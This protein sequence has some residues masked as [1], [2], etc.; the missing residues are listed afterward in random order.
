MKKDYFKDLVSIYAPMSHHTSPRKEKIKYIVIHDTGNSSR[1]AG[2]DSHVRYFHTTDRKASCDFI[3]DS[4]HIAQ[5]T[6][7]TERASWHCGDGAKGNRTITNQN[8][9]GIEMCINSDDNYKK[10]YKNTLD[11]VE[12]LMTFLDIPLD[13]VVR[14][15]DASGK[16]CPNHMSKNGWALWQTFKRD[17][18]YQVSGAKE[19]PEGI[20]SPAEAKL[21]FKQEEKEITIKKVDV[22]G[23]IFV[24]LYDLL[25]LIGY[26]ASKKDQSFYISR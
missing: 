5:I 8:S 7:F 13:R 14:H 22:D 12:A 4:K 11:I 18:A 1:G 24:P 10:M 23:K 17:L 25:E 20:T 19:A 6:N 15:F 16:I 9:L 3:V 2:A 21:I 26:S